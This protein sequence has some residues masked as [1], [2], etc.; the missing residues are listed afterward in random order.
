MQYCIDTIFFGQVCDSC[1]GGSVFK[2]LALIIKILTAGVGVL[3]VLGITI[4]G[5]MYLTSSGNEVKMAKAKN[6]IFQV[7][8]GILVYGVMFA[9]LQ[10]LIPGGILQSDLTSNTSSCPVVEEAPSSQTPS[11]QSTTPGTTPG[12]QADPDSSQS[13]PVTPDTPSGPQGKT[14]SLSLMGENWSVADT[15]ISVK[16]YQQYVYQKKIAQ[17]KK[18]CD[19]SGNC[20]TYSTLRESPDNGK[21]LN[22][23]SVYLANLYYGEKVASDKDASAGRAGHTVQGNPY[24]TS[25]KQDL[26]KEIYN[27]INAGKPVIAKVAYSF[28]PN[29]RHF[30]V[31]T[32]Y[33]SSVTSADS[34]TE[35]DLLIL[36]TNATLRYNTSSSGGKAYNSGT[37]SVGSTLT[38]FPQNGQYQIHRISS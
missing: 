31:I 12:S 20:Q 30:V 24:N 2:I 1:D 7:V 18:S 19:A 34:L 37:Y 15:A 32:G 33:K 9:V 21:C 35:N 25:S 6:R 8:I 13:T 3:A 5:I 11:S 17:D 26:L 36:D 38:L 14:T 27:Q 10:F 23:S 28:E 16:D 29:S 4:A 22:F